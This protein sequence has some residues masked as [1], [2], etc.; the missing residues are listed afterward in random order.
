[1]TLG[2]REKL[3]SIAT[4]AT[5]A[6]TGVAAAALVVGLLVLQAWV[7]GA[8][9]KT[10]GT[11]RPTAWEK[12]TDQIHDGVV[13]PEASLEAFSLLFD[14]KVPGVQA[15][16]GPNPGD[17]PRS[18]TG[19][20][21]WVDA[22]RQKLTAEQ[23]R[24]VE[25]FTATSPADVVLH[26]PPAPP[27]RSAP[28][29]GGCAS[30]TVRVDRVLQE[31]L[32]A[33]VSGDLAHIAA[34]L[35]LPVLGSDDSAQNRVTITLSNDDG[36]Q[37]LLQT[38]KGTLPG[39]AVSPCNIKL[40]RNLWSTEHP[41]D[42][43]VS[44]GLHVLLT[45]E[46]VHCYENSI[47]DQTGVADRIPSWISEGSAMYLAD[48]DAGPGPSNAA[49]WK[50]HYLLFPQTS[51]TDRTYDAIGYFS[52]LQHEG[53]NLWA[54]IAQAWRAAAGGAGISSDAASDAFI[55]VLN[56]DADDVREAWATSYARVPDWGD[57]WVMYGVGLPPKEPVSRPSV[58]AT[59]FPGLTAKVPSRAN[60][61]VNVVGATGKFVT[62]HT[63]GVASAH[64]NAGHSAL[65]F[66]NDVFCVA[67]SGC[68]MPASSC[69]PG[70]PPLQFDHLS[71]PFVLTV[72]S[73]KEGASYTV[74]SSDH[75]A[76]P[77]ASGGSCGRPSLASPAP[78]GPPP[79]QGSRPCDVGCAASTGDPHLRTVDG[80]A[81][82]FQ[83]VG[84]FT[85]L[86]WGSDEIQARHST[87]DPSDGGVQGQAIT[88]GVAVRSGNDRLTITLTDTGL[89]ARL[90]GSPAA[91]PTPAP[92]ADGGRIVSYPL[93]YEVDLA[94][95]SMLWAMA[96]GS[97]GINLELLP[98]A[99][100][101]SSGLGLL[102][103][104]AA[105][106]GSALPLLP[107]GGVLPLTIDTDARRAQLYGDFAGAWRVPASDTPFDTSPA[108]VGPNGGVPLESDLQTIG[109]LSTIQR[110]SGQT[111]CAVLTD[112][113]LRDE[114]VVDVGL[115][116][117]K[118]FVQS[119]AVVDQF[120]ATGT[121]ALS[122]PA[123]P[124]ATTGQSTSPVPAIT[125]PLRTDLQ[126][127][128]GAVM[129]SKGIVYVLVQVSD[130]K[131][132][133]LAVDPSADRILQQVDLSGTNTIAFAAD[134]VWV[135]DGCSET[136]VDGGSLATQATV[137]IG[138]GA[139][140]VV[141]NDALWVADPGHL[142][143]NG[144][145]LLQRIDPTTNTLGTGVELP[146]T[147]GTLTGTAT[148][149]FYYGGSQN[150]VFRL[151]TGQS[152]FASLGGGSGHIVAVDDGFWVQQPNGGLSQAQY[153][154]A[155]GNPQ[156]TV[157]LAD[158]LIGG[159]GDELYAIDPG[160]GG[161]Q[162]IVRIPLVGDPTPL[163]M[164]SSPLLTKSRL[165]QYD[166]ASSFLVGT[167]GSA[168]VWGVAEGSGVSLYVQWM[169]LPG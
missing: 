8:G 38:M 88:T 166:D 167:T 94:D 146:D 35:G 137:P 49:V 53:R 126:G 130:A 169:P 162:R 2:R 17:Y 158:N 48:A 86:R 79:A 36:G 60:A 131:Q 153:F 74:S 85:L 64:D 156:H 83:A 56:G 150:E 70:G 19:V 148:A 5:T 4:T 25:R 136:R 154:K 78:A 113:T 116:G 160:S 92:L 111:A 115:S 46:V 164:G 20:L 13:P 165:L 59:S 128:K 65:S 138:C 101:R 97:G 118:G 33:E 37:V 10:A 54:T 44:H 168:V 135:D 40:Y 98:S 114:C 142:G 39:G 30:D 76:D 112:R 96:A 26:P 109:D 95:G 152:A 141:A 91:L 32:C 6:T 125:F 119:Y 55:Q 22:N 51:L 145:P 9:P 43:G 18:A 42:D 45:D 47:W 82:D 24:L 58:D 105:T 134:S 161:R 21:R 50:Y 3:E 77:T 87:L 84:D 144:K 52:L 67:R 23:R 90:D 122:T 107:D 81:Y 99:R 121:Q 155:R 1:M 75:P 93:G 143:P 110:R 147:G 29:N 133:L 132:Q 103:A 129:G 139:T 127:V 72:N 104:I 89:A 149:I 12:V 159:D 100:A 69:A 123:P 14:V 28:A 106:K 61:I 140:E 120:L 34:R 62:V 151:R 63:D 68:E 73:P 66:T 16:D 57:P 163:T 15:P 7:P 80:V 117:D 124:S 71:L 108:P 41:V 11:S 157:N 27:S 31:A 102:G